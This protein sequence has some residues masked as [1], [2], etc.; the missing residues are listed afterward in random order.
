[1]VG[2]GKQIG[3]ELVIVPYKP[4]LEIVVY[5]VEIDLGEFLIHNKPVKALYKHIDAKGLQS[6]APGAGLDESWVVE[7]VDGI[8]CRLLYLGKCRRWIGRVIVEML[9]A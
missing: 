1:M 2:V 7:G 5:R 8:S 3:R 9:R 6:G 4:M